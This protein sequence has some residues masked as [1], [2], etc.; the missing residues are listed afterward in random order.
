M[1]IKPADSGTRSKE[2]S[3][4]NDWTVGS[5]RYEQRSPRWNLR[6]DLWFTY[7]YRFFRGS[8]LCGQLI[9]CF[10][11]IYE[12]LHRN[13]KWRSLHHKLEKQE[14]AQRRDGKEGT[15]AQSGL[16]LKGQVDSRSTIWEFLWVGN[17]R[18][19]IAEVQ[20]IPPLDRGCYI[21]RQSDYFRL[22]QQFLCI[23][24]QPLL[25]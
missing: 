12:R 21:P 24:V 17:P 18:T 19:R 6:I 11:K 13:K 5:S 22:R 14:T 3:R 25:L 4:L 20:T 15:T 16:R 23:H 8:Y 1:W 9:D 7:P 10:R 2:N